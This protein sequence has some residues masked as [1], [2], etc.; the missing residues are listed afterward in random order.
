[1]TLRALAA[2]LFAATLISPV[3]AEEA[4]FEQYADGA[5]A[6]YSKFKEPSKEESE[7]FFSFI[8]QKWAASSCTTECTQEGV[9][10]GKQYVSLAKVKLEN[11]I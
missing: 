6:V 5:M 7:R 3:S 1:M 2:I 10:A 8:K 11:E 4:N 9:H